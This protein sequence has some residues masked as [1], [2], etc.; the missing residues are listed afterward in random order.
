MSDV[1]FLAVAEA[2]LARQS[3]PDRPEWRPDIAAIRAAAAMVPGALP[4]R[5]NAVKVAESHRPKSVAVEGE[6][7]TNNIS[8]RTAYQVMY[9]EGYV[10]VEAGMDE[11]IHR[12]F[13]KETPEPYFPDE[14]D[15]VQQALRGSLFNVV[16]HEHA[17][18]IAGVVRTPHFDEVAPKTVVTAI[19]AWAL[20][21]QPQRPQLE[22]DASTAARFRIFDYEDH[23]P[24]APGMVALKAPGHTPGSQMIYVRLQGGG[25][26]L[27]IGD[28]AWHLDGIVKLKQKNAPWVKEDREMVGQQLAWLHDLLGAEPDV[29]IVP[30]HD[31][32]Q[33]EALLAAG[34]LGSAL[35]L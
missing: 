12:T 25:E 18:H 7:D 29:T 31:N 23:L 27:F 35:E 14:N 9:P 4:L 28:C 34:V 17:D 19:Q 6:P 22:L 1:S 13:G 21:V 15:R 20:V 30:G 11:E 8:V 10:M 2:A 3:A 24:L 26:L 5:V 32:D 33:H 16:T